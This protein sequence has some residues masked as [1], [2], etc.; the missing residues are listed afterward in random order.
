MSVFDAYCVNSSK[1]ILQPG[2]IYIVNGH[3]WLVS[4]VLSLFCFFTGEPL[5]QEQGS[6][7]RQGETSEK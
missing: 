7:H 1:L 4:C 5:L 3:P 6:R 2:P